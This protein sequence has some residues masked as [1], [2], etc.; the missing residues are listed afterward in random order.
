MSGI[1]KSFLNNHIDILLLPHKVISILP[2][3]GV[4]Q[5]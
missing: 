4:T 3:R 2:A 5:L 1:D